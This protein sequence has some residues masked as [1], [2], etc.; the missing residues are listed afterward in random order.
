MAFEDQNWN[1]LYDLVNREDFRL[2]YATSQYLFPALANQIPFFNQ[3]TFDFDHW[4]SGDVPLIKDLLARKY[5]FFNTMQ[6]W[7]MRFQNVFSPGANANQTW[8]WFCGEAGLVDGGGEWGWRHAHALDENGVP[9]V[10]RFS[11]RSAVSPTDYI[12]PWILEDLA[13]GFNGLLTVNWSETPVF[14]S[15]FD[16]SI[17]SEPSEPVFTEPS[18]P[19]GTSLASFEFSFPSN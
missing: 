19:S 2:A 6:L 11:N 5:T 15:S 4:T 14:T 12:G 1:N 9:D 18:E 17:P 10:V 16:P 3:R 7:I 8:E 13:I